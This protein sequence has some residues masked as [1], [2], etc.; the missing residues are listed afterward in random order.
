MGLH[1]GSPTT[2]QTM[3]TDKPNVLLIR[4]EDIGWFDVAACHRGTTG[5]PTMPPPSS[6]SMW[7]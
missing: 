5:T 7:N 3:A 2:E 6:S 1:G 4:A